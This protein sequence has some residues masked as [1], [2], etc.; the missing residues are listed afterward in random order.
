MKKDEIYRIGKKIGLE[1]KEIDSVISKKLS[2]EE[3]EVKNGNVKIYKAGVKYG[4]ISI[5][6]F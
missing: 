4:T 2:E 6:N 1:E 3:S 5:F